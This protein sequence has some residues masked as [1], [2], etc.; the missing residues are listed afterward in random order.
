M[1]KIF[2][3]TFEVESINS[4]CP[5]Y[6]VGDKMIFDDLTPNFDLSDPICTLALRSFS[7]RFAWMKGNN[8]AVA[9]M[10]EDGDCWLSCPAPGKPYT[11]YGRVIFRV[12][13]EEVDSDEPKLEIGCEKDPWLF[14]SRPG[15]VAC[16]KVLRKEDLK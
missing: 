7:T 12:K 4:G 2:R 13:R 10:E 3:T 9:N 15:S 14:T 16:G 1:P 6:K 11:E 5:L 8:V